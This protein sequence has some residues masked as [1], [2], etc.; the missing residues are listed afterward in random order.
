MAGLLRGKR[1]VVARMGDNPAFDQ[2]I[3]NAFMASAP[4]ERFWLEF[5][6][7]IVWVSFQQPLRDIVTLL[8][9]C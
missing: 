4:E 6:H 2:S 9:M 7:T 3:P 1:V 5:V 8:G